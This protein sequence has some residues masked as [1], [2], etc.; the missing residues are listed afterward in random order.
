MIPAAPPHT[1]RRSEPRSAPGEGSKNCRKR[2]ALSENKKNCFRLDEDKARK[3]REEHGQ[4]CLLV[5]V[6]AAKL[7]CRVRNDSNAIGSIS[8][9]ETSPSFVSPHFRQTLSHRH[10]V[11]F[12]AHALY[13]EQDLQS[14]QRRHDCARHGSCHTSSAKCRHDWL[15]DELAEL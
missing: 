7:N 10:L 12:P 9:H 6:I 2:L 5:K 4:A 3:G 15:R 11:F 13:L 1:K 8:S 14:F